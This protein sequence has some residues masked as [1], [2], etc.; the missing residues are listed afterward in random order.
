MT[1]GLALKELLVFLL[2]EGSLMPEDPP[3]GL[4]NWPPV[5]APTVPVELP[6]VN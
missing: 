3:C 1:S 4:V 6:S 2:L 5:E